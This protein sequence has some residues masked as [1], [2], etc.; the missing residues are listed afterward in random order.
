M[1]RTL[2]SFCIIA[3]LTTVSPGQDKFGPDDPLAAI[4][5]NPIFLGELNLILVD[6]LRISDPSKA[7]AQV[8]QAT[9]TLL[10]RQHLALR[11]LKQQ[12]G[13]SLQQLI[14]RQIATVAADAKRR[15]TSLQRQ[16]EQRKSNEQSLKASLE[17]QVAWKQFLQSR[18]TDKNLRIFFERHRQHYAGGRWE[19]SQLFLK[20][21]PSDSAQAEETQRRLTALVAELRSSTSPEIAFAQAAQEHSESG[22]ATEG[23]KVGWV[24]VDGDL[25][26]S[27]MNVVRNSKPGEVSMPVRSPLGLHLVFVHQ[28]EPKDLEFEE[29]TDQTQLRRDATDAMFENLVRQQSDAKVSWFISALKPPAGVSLIPNESSKQ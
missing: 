26:R 7:T 24:E 8:Q 19:V 15:G 20:V 29:L 5:G 4:D 17:W 13:Q 2:L 27:V 23:G 18:L 1:N 10:V 6:N 14:D 3:A 21:D 11:T 25:P 9:A 12:G 22:S 16:A 28:H